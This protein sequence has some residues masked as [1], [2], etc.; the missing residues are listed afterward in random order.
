LIREGHPRETIDDQTIAHVYGI[1]GTVGRLPD[2]TI[3]Y[4]LPQTRFTATC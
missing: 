4:V 2:P 3:P 1:A